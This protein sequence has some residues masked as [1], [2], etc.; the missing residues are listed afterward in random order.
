MA[1]AYQ[2]AHILALGLSTPRVGELRDLLARHGFQNVRGVAEREMALGAVLSN[3]PDL[4]LVWVEP[5]N[6]AD[7]Q[8]LED[9]VTIEKESYVAV[10]AV[11]P[12]F[13][14][15]EL[16]SRARTIPAMRLLYRELSEEKARL[17]A[18]AGERAK[19]YEDA[20]ANLKSAETHL[21]AALAESEDKSR[22]KSDFIANLSHEFRTPLNAI[23]G[24]SEILKNESFGSHSSPKYKE[25]AQ[26]IHGA[27]QHLLGLI[28]DVLDLSRAEAGRLDLEFTEVDASRT[29]DSAVR[30]L[31]DKAKA[32]GITMRVDIAPDFPHLRTDERRLRQVLLNI[33]GNAI[34]FTPPAG[35]VAI[36]AGV[37]P[38]DGAFIIVVTDTGVG[39]DP[40][41]LPRVMSRYGQV[42]NAKAGNE[43]GS[44]IGLPLTQ[45]VVEALGGTLEIR[46]ERHKGTAVTLRFPPSLI[47]PSD[48][49]KPADTAAAKRAAGNGG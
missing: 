34:K 33:V 13:D 42:K 23:L 16:V 31:H 19:K 26:D 29:I 18:E 39:I 21:S 40:A 20:I 3:R 48:D 41:D 28:T 49:G 4:V 45:K 10:V 22:S 14:P 17:E 2:D 38:A 15:E 11:N 46:S 7:E 30:M 9:I 1:I 43:H 12:D 5:G 8:L 36:K 37:D 25:Y 47:V 6:A 35:S 32:K 24:F 27:A 44:G